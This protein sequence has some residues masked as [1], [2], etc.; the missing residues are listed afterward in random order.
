MY[1]YVYVYVCI[2]IYIY[3]LCIHV[4]VYVYI[5]IYIYIYT[6]ICA[7]AY[8]YIYIYIYTHKYAQHALYTSYMLLVRRYANLSHTNT[9]GDCTVSKLAYN[10]VLRPECTILLVVCYTYCICYSILYH[11]LYYSL[12]TILQYIILKHDVSILSHPRGPQ[13][14]GSL[15]ASYMLRKGTG[16]G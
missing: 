4:C 14:F 1:V 8:V 3:T 5:Y 12:R 11:V 2:Y 16:L 13:R 6:C 7:Y 10:S 15:M 9:S